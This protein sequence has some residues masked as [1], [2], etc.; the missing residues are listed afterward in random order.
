M[1]S[2]TVPEARDWIAF[3]LADWSAV[4]IFIICLFLLSRESI[5]WGKCAISNRIQNPLFKEPHLEV[6]LTEQLEVQLFRT[7]PCYA[8][9]AGLFLRAQGWIRSCHVLHKDTLPLTCC[10]VSQSWS[11]KKEKAGKKGKI[12]HQVLPVRLAATTRQD[13]NECVVCPRCWS[14]VSF[15]KSDEDLSLHAVYSTSWHL[16]LLCWMRAQS[17][18]RCRLLH[19]PVSHRASCLFRSLCDQTALRTYR[20]F[21]ERKA[22]FSCESEDASLAVR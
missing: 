2:A 3:F 21:M 18:R 7:C 14:S 12:C 19:A 11:R 1:V 17:R 5:S 22:T 8:R 15:S 4:G 13:A 16:T 10:L 20:A 6:M 9:F